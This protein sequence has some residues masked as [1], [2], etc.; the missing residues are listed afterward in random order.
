MDS[1]VKLETLASI[2]SALSGHLKELVQVSG[3][4]LDWNEVQ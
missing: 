3:P 2:G 1:E 4:G